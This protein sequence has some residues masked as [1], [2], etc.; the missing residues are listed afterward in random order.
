VT[1]EPNIVLL[2]KWFILIPAFNSTGWINNLGPIRK[3]I[4]N[5][6][7]RGFLLRKLNETYLTASVLPDREVDAFVRSSLLA[8]LALELERQDRPVE[9]PETYCRC[10]GGSADTESLCSSCHQ[11]MSEMLL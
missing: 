8:L 4:L 1:T 3:S 5:R 2:N 11:G 6:M 7:D 9:I 10:C